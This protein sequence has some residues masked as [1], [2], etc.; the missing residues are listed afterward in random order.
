MLHEKALIQKVEIPYYS[1]FLPT[2]L[3][4][5]MTSLPPAYEMIDVGAPTVGDPT[6][7]NA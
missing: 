1:L 5:H 2:A 6:A 7:N 4:F 3:I